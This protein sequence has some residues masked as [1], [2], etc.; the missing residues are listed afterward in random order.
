VTDGTNETLESCQL[1]RLAIEMK[2]CNDSAQRDF[3]S[4][5]ISTKIAPATADNMSR[6]LG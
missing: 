2:E 4:R 1:R 3:D 6:R 5:E